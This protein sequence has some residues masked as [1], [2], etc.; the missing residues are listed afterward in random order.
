MHDLFVH[1]CAFA[2][3]RWVLTCGVTEEVLEHDA[4]NQPGLENKER[5]S[6]RDW[7]VRST[8]KVQKIADEVHVPGGLRVRKQLAEGGDD[9]RVKP[10][11]LE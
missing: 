6:L 10:L 11:V 2:S 4:A 8:V 1:R 7:R 3:E 5:K 9:F